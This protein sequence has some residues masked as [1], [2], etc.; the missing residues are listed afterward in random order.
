MEKKCKACGSNKMGGIYDFGPMPLVNAFYDDFDESSYSPNLNLI[1][2]NECKVCQLEE[3]P[4][5][6]K[7]FAK[8]KHYSGASKDNV[9]HLIK[10]AQFCNEFKG[11]LEAANVLEIGCNDGTLLNEFKK[12]GANIIGCDA[13]LNMAD[14]P[15]HKELNTVF[16]PFGH[17]AAKIILNRYSGKK[18][19]LILGLNVFAHYDSVYESFCEISNMLNP[20]NGVFMFE[21]AYALDTVFAK[22]YD[23]I[24]HEH[25]FNHTLIGLDS[26]LSSANM[27][28]VFA[29]RITTQ[30]GSLRVVATCRTNRINYP[31]GEH[32]EILENERHLGIDDSDY[33]INAGKAIHESIIEREKSLEKFIQGC[34]SLLLAGSP[35]RGVVFANTMRHVLDGKT[36][37]PLDDTKDKWGMFFPGFPYKVRSFESLTDFGRMPNVAILLSWNYKNTILEKLRVHGFKGKVFVPFP[38]IEILEL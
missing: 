26:M 2:C 20:E 17:E 19:D 25:L 31:R 37:I 1:Y 22:N 36:L 15:I 8:Y 5:V 10:V 21:V 12:I 28:I 35:A 14:L 16:V 7:L 13:A 9:S 3:A 23:T 11:G 32:F 6:G 4:S 29:E 38:N 34:D 18:F 27:K 24:Y 33:Y 30:G